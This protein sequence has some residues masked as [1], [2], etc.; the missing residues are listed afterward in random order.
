MYHVAELLE[1]LQTRHAEFL[2]TR[3]DL[4]SADNAKRFIHIERDMMEIRGVLGQPWCQIPPDVQQCIER[5]R[6]EVR[7]PP[8]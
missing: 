3:W 1:V 2:N 6:E 5:I 7:L 4:L 8:N